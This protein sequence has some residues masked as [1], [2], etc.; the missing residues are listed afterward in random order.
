MADE[1]YRDLGGPF[2]F[3]AVMIVMFVALPIAHWLG[4]RDVRKFLEN[5]RRDSA[6]HG[7]NE[8]D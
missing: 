2:L 5:D 6:V 4:R 3:I 7:R 1:Y 8:R